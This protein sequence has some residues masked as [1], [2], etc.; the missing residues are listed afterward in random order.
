MLKIFAVFLVA[1]FAMASLNSCGM[2]FF[3]PIASSDSD[4]YHMEQAR[5]YVDQKKY[6]DAE[7]SLAKVEGN[8]NEKT[9]LLVGSKLGNVGLS[10][11]EILLDVVDSLTNSSSS[12]SS[13][14]EQVF[15]VFSDTLF[16]TGDERDDKLEAINE[17]IALIRS[18]PEQ[19][20]KMEAFR[21]FL[22]GI[23]VLP[24]VNDGTSA[25]VNVTTALNSLES[26]VSGDGSNGDQCPGL[27]AF[28]AAMSGLE[29]VRNGL[30]FIIQ[31]TADC[32]LLSFLSESG[33]LNAISE[34]L[35]KFVEAADQG[36]PTI[37]C[38][39]DALCEALQLGCVADLLDTSS[40]VAGDGIVDQCELVYNCTTAGTCF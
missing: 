37:T 12:S 39:N 6:A 1:G 4:H 5:I 28:Q 19:D 35:R 32:E 23:Y 15:N 2:N 31:Q 11:W 9:L 27:D 22:S 18:A 17:S 38:N 40:A 16:G 36:C 3:E 24:I 21:C 10:L 25:M 33:D 26:S 7:A 34:R 30:D 14:M 13:G 8:S 29:T 20:S